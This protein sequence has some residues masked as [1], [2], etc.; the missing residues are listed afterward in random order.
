MNPSALPKLPSK[1]RSSDTET[2]GS[3]RKSKQQKIE[4]DLTSPLCAHCQPFNLDLKFEMAT[5]GYQRL[6]DGL[7][8]FPET[9]YGASDGSYFYNDA[10]CVHVFKDQLSE[11]LD[12]LLCQFFRSLRVHSERYQQHKLPS[13][14]SSDSWLFRPDLLRK[15]KVYKKCKD[16]VFVAVVPYM[17]IQ[18]RCTNTWKTC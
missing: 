10:V 15:R 5:A 14:R 1:K 17:S 16:T 8:S 6:A 9:I 11:P 3:L 12:C 13:F 2:E 18:F 4:I 7:T